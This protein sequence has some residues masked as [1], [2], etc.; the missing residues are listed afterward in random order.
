MA[1]YEDEP[2]MVLEKARSGRS[3]YKNC[4]ENIESDSIRVGIKGFARGRGEYRCPFFF[5]LQFFSSSP[6]SSIA[7]SVTLFSFLRCSNS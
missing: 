5:Y 2:F 7:L 1:E 4:K 3:A 6:S